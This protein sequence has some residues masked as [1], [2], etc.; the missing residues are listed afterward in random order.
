MN[1]FALNC[2]AQ[3]IIS[4]NA[5]HVH[6]LGGF[7][8]DKLAGLL[9]NQTEYPLCFI[10]NTAPS[11]HVG[12]HWVA[13]YFCRPNRCEFFDSLGRHPHKYYM[14]S[15]IPEVELTLNQIEFQSTLS[16]VCGEYCIFFL[17]MRC[18]RSFYAVIHYLASRFST[19]QLRDN[20]MRRYTRHLAIR[21]N[22]GDQLCD[23]SSCPSGAQC[24]TSYNAWC[25]DLPPDDPSHEYK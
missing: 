18:S 12:K 9:N 22:L 20:F 4:V 3:K 7:A 1:S 21:Y 24:C 8:V 2:L 25:L 5:R 10:A 19:C 16:T 23:V 17:Y 13:F 15:G 14:Y 6:L 11:N